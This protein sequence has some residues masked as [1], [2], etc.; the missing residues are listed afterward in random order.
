MIAEH[1]NP[2]FLRELYLDGCD[3]VTDQSLSYLVGKSTKREANYASMIEQKYQD[4]NSS[5]QMQSFSSLATT[6]EEYSKVI[7]RVSHGGARGLELISLAECKGINDTG[8][9]Q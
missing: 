1:A 5:L 7:N 6:H 8:I 9:S 4:F 2:F 3:K